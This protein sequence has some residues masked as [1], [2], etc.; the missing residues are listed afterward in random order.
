MLSINSLIDAAARCTLERPRYGYVAPEYKQAKAVAWDYL[1]HY[2]N[3]FPGVKRNE[4]ELFVELPT[5]ARIRLFGADNPDSLRGLY[6]D[7]VVLDEVAQMR[8]QVWEEIIRPALVDRNGWALFIG[9]P[10]GV[11]LFSDL[12]FQAIDNQEWFAGMFRASETGIIPQKELDDARA[13]M[14]ANKYAQ[15]F[16]CDFTASSEDILIPLELAMEATGREYGRATYMLAPVILGVDIARFGDDRSVIIRRQGLVSSVLHILRDV[17]TMHLAGVLSTVIEREKPDATFLDMGAMGPGVY[18]RLR[19]LG[20]NVTGV[21]FGAKADA[22]SKYINKRT[23]M[24]CLMRDW[25]TDGGSLAGGQDMVRDVSTIRYS[26]DPANRIKL[27]SKE[28]AKKRINASPDLGDALALT[29]AYPVR[30][31]SDLELA[32][33]RFD[34]SAEDYDPLHAY[35]GGKKWR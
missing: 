20:Y 30:M 29:F 21:Y 2:T 1:K 10:N 6:W 23:E 27:E 4:S 17:D 28:D 33:E 5:G 9:T 15:E 16:E 24:W 25:L 12:Y 34:T 11:N 26:Y 35:R 7:G 18:D 8:N 32:Q 13:S 14:S 19:Q 3:A 31:K 22:E